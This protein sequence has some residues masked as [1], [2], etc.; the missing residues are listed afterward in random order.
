M[1][2]GHGRACVLVAAL[3]AGVGSI[4]VSCGQP[5]EPLDRERALLRERLGQSRAL[6]APLSIS[7]RWVP[8][9]QTVPRPGFLLPGL[10]C[11][12]ESA[13]ADTAPSASPSANRGP[14]ETA[15]RQLEPVAMLHHR[16]LRRLARPAM[17]DRL[18]E[19]IVLLSTARELR[20][21]D[22]D[23]LVD[24]AAARVGR[25][26]RDDQPYDLAT[27]LAA[28]TEALALAP[29]GR[30]ARFTHA[31]CLELL[32]FEAAAIEAWDAFLA[33]EGDSSWASEAA[34][35][36]Q[37]L[38][39][40]Q[41]TH[42]QAEVERTNPPN[43]GTAEDAR[44][45]AQ[46]F[47]QEA[48]LW[49]QATLLGEWA[50]GSSPSTLV[51]VEAVGEVLAES[52][53]DP[54]I[55]D[56]AR[57]LGDC[58]DRGCSTALREGVSWLAEGLSS[59]EAWRLTEALAS[60]EQAAARLEQLASP[61]GL[62]ARFN[63]ALALYRLD[64]PVA[65]ARGWVALATDLELK[66]YV[67]LEARVFWML[68][69]CDLVLPE[70]QRDRGVA[71]YRRAVAG[72]EATGEAG[73]AAALRSLISQALVRGGD[74][75]AAWRALY[76]TLHGLDA[77][78]AR[79]WHYFVGA[80]LATVAEAQGEAELA[81]RFKAMAVGGLSEDAPAARRV[82][83]EI[84]YAR[85][86]VA[87][88]HSAE[89]ETL[90]DRLRLQVADLE[91]PDLRHRA[92][93]DLDLVEADIL[94]STVPQAA[95]EKYA[96]ALDYF[97]ESAELPA[98]QVL[99]QLGQARAWRRQGRVD[100]ARM[101]L[102]EAIGLIEQRLA[103]ETHWA[104][105]VGFDDPAEAAY[106]EMIGL[107]AQQTEA[108]AERL[109]WVERLRR[110]RWP[111]DQ[112][113]ESELALE[114]LSRV[115]ERLGPHDRLVVLAL[116]EGGIDTWVDGPSELEAVPPAA[117]VDPADI[118]RSIR[119]FSAC[120]RASIEG[121]DAVHRSLSAR[122]VAPW[123][124]ALSTGDRV[125]LVVDGPLAAL[126]F[127]ALKNPRTGR[128]IVEDHA[129]SVV[130]TLDMVWRG[131]GREA[132]RRDALPHGRRDGGDS[133]RGDSTA[134]GPGGRTVGSN[135][136]VGDPAFPAAAFP[137]LVRL[138]GARE[139]ARAVAALDPET[140]FFEAEAAT[141]AAVTA[142]LSSASLFHAAAHTLLHPR[143]PEASAIV[144][145]AEASDG[146]L[147]SLLTAAEI[148][149][150]DLAGLR[151]AVLSGCRSLADSSL[152]ASEVYGMARAFVAAGTHSVLATLWPI[153]DAAAVPL[154]QAFHR[155]LA[156]GHSTA[157]ALRQA[158][159]TVQ[160][161]SDREVP[162]VWA[163]QLIGI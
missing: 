16:A 39:T 154:L 3:A 43:A 113:T 1:R 105:D 81:M 96:S 7:A 55:R 78:V 70:G 69:L 88:G 94:L 99:C 149:R 91:E 32:G 101:A 143:R 45:F 6:L 132:R 122:L 131:L 44:A 140:V 19:A 66:A 97:R 65:A 67:A 128:R 51:L 27:A 2:L 145:A 46:R 18:D 93:A 58:D 12:P 26:E 153:D 123:S 95:G 157:Q 34:V 136:V 102:S 83:A 5:A 53:G 107:L 134:K 98:Y 141:P 121:C 76:S 35:R 74:E 151:V 21:D 135:V 162:S 85:A 37:R 106:R 61:L 142:A 147:A 111:T 8:P 4:V 11:S 28:A 108:E 100:A 80:V 158:Q 87:A 22:A 47:P 104:P 25:A 144:L 159:R 73:H 54:W 137:S 23:I 40:R 17:H 110:Y 60:L 41:E 29:H 31:L 125:I 84:W 120:L 63:H 138:P 72:F 103:A 68:G 163:F 59:V 56:V 79:Y 36:R 127:A 38:A 156:A 160:V 20:P 146:R 150:L 14:V 152:G 71:R 75:R 33:L 90:H 57:S 117:T 15:P 48:R 64:R 49:V 92:Q 124:E 119:A 114:S 161:A 133:G 24:L 62:L 148:A 109:R 10:H 139:E 50:A 126:P 42:R 155:N 13:P 30:F 52:Y 86:L 112:D 89:A 129:L 130:P 118:R 82:D 115:P 77:S 9:C 116:R